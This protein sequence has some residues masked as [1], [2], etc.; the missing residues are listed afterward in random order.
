MKG[1]GTCPARDVIDHDMP[2]TCMIDAGPDG[3]V[4]EENG[5]VI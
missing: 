1:F 4:V 3:A 2:G 5:D